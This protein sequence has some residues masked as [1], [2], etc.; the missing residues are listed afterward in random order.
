LTKKN[1]SDKIPHIMPEQDRIRLASLT[2]GDL[3]RAVAGSEPRNTYKYDFLV[4][5]PG[6]KPTCL[7]TQTDPK[8]KI[9]G[10]LELILEGTGHR[11][12]RNQNPVMDH[13]GQV[14]IFDGLLVKGGTLIVHIP[15]HP[16]FERAELMPACTAFEVY[17]NTPNASAA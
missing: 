11:L 15:T 6:E 8:G 12:N 1:Q 2:E 17:P 16:I 10:T 4:L 14:T 3:V 7:F 5:K 13:D 9:T